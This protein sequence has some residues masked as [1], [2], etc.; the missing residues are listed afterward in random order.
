[1]SGYVEYSS[2]NSGGTWWLADEH[3]HALEAAGWRVQWAWQSPLY[4]EKGGYV[5][6]PETGLPKLVLASENNSKYSFGC[7]AEGER[8]LGAL[9]KTAFRVG[10]GL[11]EAA[12]EW[13]RITG[14]DATDAGCACCGQPHNFT[15]YDAAGKWLASGPETEYVARWVD[16]A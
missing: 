16:D 5:R 2:N 3:W 15:E 8:W 13:E 14:Q 9:A 4:D 7:V 12:S 10:L 6:E 1:M 11:R